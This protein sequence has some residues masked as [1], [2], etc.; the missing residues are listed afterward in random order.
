MPIDTAKVRLRTLHFQ[1][2]DQALAEAERIVHSSRAGKLQTLGNW[3]PGQTLS[4]L[5]WWIEAIDQPDKVPPLPWYVKLLGPV[6]KNKLITST[7]KPGAKLPGAPT[8]THGDA[9]A[10]LDEGLTRFRAAVQRLNQGNFPPRHPV[11]GKMSQQDWLN[12]HLRHA[13]LHLGFL[14]PSS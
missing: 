8:G 1:T 7:P 2:P 10:T 13:E 14:Q 6:I 9:P 5:A 4:H 3:T 11:F 12:L